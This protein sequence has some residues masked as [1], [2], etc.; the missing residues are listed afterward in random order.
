MKAILSPSCFS[1]ISKFNTFFL[2]FFLWSYS[3]AQNAWTQVTDVPGTGRIGAV[4]FSINNKGYLGTGSDGANFKKDFWEYDPNS[5]TWTQKADLGGA[6]REYAVGFALGTY[7]YIGTGNGT[8]DNKDDFWQYNPVSNTWTQKADFLGAPRYRAT[9]FS[10]GNKGYLGTGYTG[11][12]TKKDFYEYDPATDTWTQKA[13]VGGVGRWM[14]VS[15]VIGEK[16]YIGTARN[17]DP[18][19]E[20]D[21]W[22]YDPASDTWAEKA[23]MPGPNRYGAVA[24]AI[25]G[26]GYVATGND[27]EN[28][29]ALKDVYE[30]DPV[31]GNWTQKADFAGSPRYFAVGFAIG[32]IGFIGTGELSED[33]YTNDFW[34]F[35][36]ACITPTGLTTTN[37]KATSAKVNWALESSAQSYSVRYRKTGT[38]PWTKITAPFNFKKLAGLTPGTQ[39]DWSVKSVCDVVNNIS[40]NWSA[41]QNFNTKPLKLGEEDSDEIWMEVYPNPLT[42]ASVLSLFVSQ[43]SRFTFE[44][45]DLTGRKIATVADEQFA[46]GSHEIPLNADQLTEGTY[47]LRMINANGESTIKLVVE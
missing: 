40:S 17:S 45:F 2:L 35:S 38:I 42:E 19:Y 30:Y 21:L 13:N 36:P 8:G 22:E 18:P 32:N 20:N 46:E 23:T 12:A 29:L 44:L 6:A 15:F 41:I 5:N 27:V 31:T 39:Y 14:A 11:N 37:I 47:L 25:E 24:F 33:N 26:K 43:S 3:D 9:G 28:D 4:G 7:G 34:Q 16:G 10:I 1:L